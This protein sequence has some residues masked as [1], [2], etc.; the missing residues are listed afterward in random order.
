AAAFMSYSWRFGEVLCK[1]VHYVQ[2]VSMIC[3]VMT[4]TCISL[5]RVVAVVSP[6]KART[7]CTMRHA[8]IVVVLVWILST[9]C[10]LP[11]VFGMVHLEVG[12]KVKAHWCIKHFPDQRLHILYEIYMLVLMF[13]IPVVVMVTTY[14]II[15][16]Q[17]WKFTDMR[18]SENVHKRD[19]RQVSICVI[20]VYTYTR[21]LIVMLVVVVILFAVCWGPILINNLLVAYGTLHNLNYGYLKPMRAAFSLLCYINSCVNPIVYAFMSKNFRQSFKFAICACVKGKA[22]VRA[23][24][25]SMSITNSTRASTLS[26]GR[27]RHEAAQYRYVSLPDGLSV[28]AC[29]TYFLFLSD[30]LDTHA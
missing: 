2:N 19:G 3:S 28:I 4:L 11:I 29:F 14:V 6:L 24:R 13:I 18:I 23:Y 17:V 9:I 25:F 5:E 20:Y 22:F 12:Y 30:T 15:C 26:N 7:V 27:G 1:L 8:K 16:I 21:F 10:A